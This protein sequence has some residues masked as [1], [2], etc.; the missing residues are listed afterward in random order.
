[1]QRV[2]GGSWDV[3]LT[4]VMFAGTLPAAPSD[5]EIEVLTWLAGR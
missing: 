2:L 5:Y 3:R 1:R 4:R